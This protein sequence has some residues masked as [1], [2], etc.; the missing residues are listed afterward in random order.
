MAKQSSLAMKTNLKIF[1]LAAFGLLLVLVAGCGFSKK[2]AKEKQAQSSSST[3]P[4]PPTQP[5]TPTAP[6][7]SGADLELE[8][9]SGI[10]FIKSTQLMP[11]LEEAN[12]RNLPV[13]VEFWAPWC[14][15]C[16]TLEREVF[17]TLEV[18]NFVN[19]NFLSV[20]LNL[21]TED[22]KAVA[23]LYDSEKL[24]T[25]LFLNKKG[26]ELGRIVGTTTPGRFIRAGAEALEKK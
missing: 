3:T 25:M 4:M 13:F 7:S 14:G 2:S 17:N 18:S 22:G 11:V 10:N 26:I 21:D 12:I 24:P 23:Q 1:L 5:S 15:P 19:E 8:Q 20:K 16:K 9:G 6:T